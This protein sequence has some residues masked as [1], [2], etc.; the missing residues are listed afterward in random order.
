MHTYSNL[1]LN[2]DMI[3]NMRKL[4]PLILILA[5]VV[6]RAV[7]AEQMVT[8]PLNDFDEARYAEVAH[9]IVRTGN[10]ILPMAGGPDEPRNIPYFTLPNNET[11]YPYF[12]KPPLHTAFIAVM[13]YIFG[14]NEF[15]V[16]LPS[17]IAGCVVIAMV[18]GITYK[19]SGR[20]LFAATI[21]G[22]ALSVSSDFS[23]I[24]S[25]G[26][27]EVLFL[28]F[29]VGACAVVL[30]KHQARY[31]ISG[32]LF[33]L[34]CMTKSFAAFWIPPVVFL[35][36]WIG[37]FTSAEHGHAKKPK[38]MDRFMVRNV[39]LFV[40]GALAIV[41]PW[42]LF[43]YVQFGQ[44]FIEGYFTNNLIGRATG[45]Q[46]NIAP[47]YWYM[48]Y[49]MREHTLLFIL[50]GWALI[51]LYLTYAQS[52]RKIWLFLLAWIAIVFAPFSFMQSKVWWYVFPV[53]VPMAV[54]VGLSLAHG[55]GNGLRKTMNIIV[56]CILLVVVG[57]HSMIVASARDFGT[58]PI[59]SLGMRHQNVT[60]LAV[61]G[62]AYEATLFYFS[63]GNVTRDQNNAVHIVAP[64]SILDDLKREGFSLLD[65]EQGWGIYKRVIPIQ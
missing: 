9:N 4:Y 14:V 57:M 35:A 37:E 56:V 36:A 58:D 52:A 3:G 46:Q 27:A 23:F 32:I 10:W 17:L 41:L 54:G 22:I 49:F 48:L 25:Q 30:S 62:R 19:L 61:L 39:L 5:F 7:C 29:A 2:T 59:R 28:A 45:A 24:T 21:A 26:I 20:S 6:L 38:D 13:Y 40:I 11:L 65:E 12:W 47:F 15:A 44:A 33:G 31:L 1:D 55:T 53:W 51:S 18:Y 42:H 60:D 16:R 50:T 8:R 64:K 34:A 43:M 63:S